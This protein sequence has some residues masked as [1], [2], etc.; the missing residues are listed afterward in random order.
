[1]T[2]DITNE[3]QI[4]GGKYLSTMNGEQNKDEE[5]DENHL[6][7]L[8]SCSNSTTSTVSGRS[9]SVST[10]VLRKQQQINRRRAFFQD[11]VVSRSLTAHNNNNNNTNHSSTIDDNQ[12][13]LTTNNDNDE[14]NQEESSTTLINH[15]EENPTN[16]SFKRKAVSF[17]T[18]PFE[19]KVADVCDCLRYMQEGSDFLKVRS[20]A[21]QFRRLYKL[22]ETLTA[23]SWYP[24]SKKPSKA[25]IAIDSIKE[26]RLGK[27]TERLREYT[28]QFQNE[29]FFSIIY[30]NGNNQYASLDLVASSADEANIWVTGLSCLIAGQGSAPSPADFE[31]RQQMRDRW[32][33]D[34]FTVPEQINR[35]EQRSSTNSM[36]EEEAIRLLID[37]GISEEK[38]KVRLQ[39]IQS[40]KS[41]S[42]RG[43]FTTDELINVFKELSTRPE[44]YHLLVRYS[45]N[46]DF[47]STEDLT[48]FLEAEQGNSKITREKCAEIIQEFEP[49]AEAKLAGHLG[50]DGFTNYLLSPE[51]DIF[52]PHNRNVCQEMDHPLNHYF[53]ASSHNTFLL[54]DQLKGPSSVDGFIHALMRGCR[55][56]E[57]HCFDGADGQP[58]VHNGT[59]TTRI[60]VNEALE[61]INN[62]AFE[63]SSYPLI[64]CIELQ[65]AVSQQERLAQLLIEIFGDKI[66]LDHLTTNVNSISNEYRPLPSPNDLRG[67]IIIKGK[68]L[69]PSFSNE[70]NKEYG[71]ITDDEDCYEDNKRRSKK[72][73]NSKRHRRLALA[74]SDLVTLLRSGPFEDFE[75]SS[76]EQQSG[77]VCT[78]SESAGLRLATSDAEEFVN[79]NKRFLSRISPGTWRVDSSNLNPQDFWN[80][81]CQMV[82]MNYQTAG[83]FM[84]VYFGRFLSNGGCGYVLKPTYLRYDNAAAA[85]AAS[86][87]IISGRFS[88]NVYS[89]NTPQI[90]HIKVISALHLPKPEQAELKANSVDPYVV[91]QIFGVP[92]DC[93]EVRTKTVYHN[94]ESPQF[95]EA[96]EFEI[97]FPE[98][99][100]VRFVVLD[101]E[102]LDYDF[103]GQY[104]LPFDCIQPGYRHVHLYTIGGDLIANAY[105]FVHIVVNSK[106]LAVKPRRSMSRYRRSLLR[107]KLRVAAFR[108]VNHRQIDD[109]FKSVVQP[110]ETAFEYRHAV[111]QSLCELN[112]MCGLP[113]ISNVKQ[114]VRKIA[115]RLQKGNL[116]GAV[117]IRNQSDI[118]I[119][120]YASTLPELT[121]QSV[122]ALEEVINRCRALIDNGSVIHKKLFSV[123]SEVCEL[124]KDIP[125]LLEGS[126]LRG[127]KFTKAIDNFSYDLAL[128]HGQTDLL[129]KAKQDAIVTIRQILEAAETTHLLVQSE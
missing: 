63:T 76:N 72:D 119:F 108:P 41:E 29:S 73:T 120:E 107:R 82:A 78:F 20:Y 19:K 6:A 45:R 91:V 128:L 81:G 53:I 14:I 34:A 110:L 39:E 37:Y 113:D 125:K 54:A 60:P 94:C 68:K 90:L 92:R 1:M 84:D 12:Q 97:A 104:T 124:S 23:I 101:D 55:C 86:S 8:R 13:I 42:A 118:P 103:I 5:I 96:F 57:L 26:I 111:E 31:D 89:S 9:S 77:Q 79:Y 95:N 46:Q 28:H 71:E 102:S 74:F 126:G 21:R 66:F 22:N 109:L 15:H 88:T 17:S 52:N 87:S 114:C 67:K 43:F 98:L 65:C 18:M 105:L 61:A 35:D 16:K 10:S 25:M 27:T 93:D 49:S 69:P 122:V 80:V 117:T 30:T 121:R 59:L 3:Q 127:K 38:A 56:L 11:D 85:A 47:L 83:K 48:L 70:I 123:Q 64:L 106:S 75:T 115:S 24:T 51:C 36:D 129:N 32:L 58:T 2:D 112:E 4:N 33:R 44:I 99:T 40:S 7:N 116:V 62:Y 50:I 100:L